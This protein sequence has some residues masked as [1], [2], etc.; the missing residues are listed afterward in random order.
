MSES[1]IWWLMA[2]LAV[3]AELVTGTFYLLMMAVGLIAGAVAA[4]LG[5][6]MIGQILFSAAIGSSA[7]GAWHWQRGKRPAPIEANSNPDV[8]L[9]I[10]EAVMVTR[11]LADGTAIVKF[12]GA[13]WTA[14][15]A[16]PEETEA[17][18]LFRIKEM[19]GNRLVIEK[20]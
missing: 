13:N 2:G 9:D 1:T 11:W 6:S 16:T 18:G 12:R 10:G 4:H 15:A 14:V 5:F 17:P 19:L 8:H 3:A 7:V 20:Q